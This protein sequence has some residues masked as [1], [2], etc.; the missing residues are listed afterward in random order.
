MKII[1]K[2]IVILTGVIA[3]ISGVIF[4]TGNDILNKVKIIRLDNNY[5]FDKNFKIVLDDENVAKLEFIKDGLPTDRT[6]GLFYELGEQFKLTSLNDLHEHFK[7]VEV[8][9][10]KH[11]NKNDASKLH[12]LYKK[13][14]ESEVA[15]SSSSEFKE[16]SDSTGMLLF[17][18]N[19]IYNFRIQKLGKPLTDAL[20]GRDLKKREYSTRRTII[21]NDQTLY[22]KEK[23][24]KL[25]ELK[26]GM[27][28]EIP[29][30]HIEDSNSFNKYHFK[31]YLY[32][33]DLSELSK[34]DRDK[35]IK[36]YRK[37]FFTTQELQKLDEVDTQLAEEM[38]QL[39]LYR[40]SETEILNLS[41]NQEL[42]DKKIRELQDKFFGSE[43][44]AFRRAESAKKFN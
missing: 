15:L 21:I 7:Q 6:L 11:F 27:W 40:E 10:N 3:V 12:E 18:L 8:Y 29:I 24:K 14:L 25:E 41:L 16:K 42:K 2:K 39:K 5:I 20:F 4:F 32:N 23:E 43:A 17:N 22:G 9:L 44:E 37:E 31:I 1:N 28:G 38:H 30:Y 19:E 34:N 33:K 26:I 36:D 35:K 13:Y